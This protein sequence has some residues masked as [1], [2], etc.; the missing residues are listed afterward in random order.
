MAVTVQTPVCPIDSKADRTIITLMKEEYS[1]NFM[2]EPG[3]TTVNFFTG[4]IE[5]A[6]IYYKERLLL[7]LQQNP[8]LAGRLEVDGTDKKKVNLSYPNIV[9][10]NVLDTIFLIDNTLNINRTMSYEQICDV[11]GKHTSGPGGF[12]PKGYMILKSGQP[13]SKFTLAP[14][15]SN[16]GFVFIPSLSHVV[17]DGHTKYKILSMLAQNA[18][19]PFGLEIRRVQS[20]SEAS[21]TVVGAAQQAL[22]YSVP[23]LMNVIGKVLFGCGQCKI[24]SFYVADPVRLEALKAKA[25][26]QA[27]AEGVILPFV[28]T[29]DILTSHFARLTSAR[30]L[31]YAVNLRARIPSLL[32]E[33]YAGNYE[34]AIMLDPVTYATPLKVRQVGGV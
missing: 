11:V 29:A 27:A 14:D 33:D 4:S 8:W 10:A 20:Y 25:K 12:V 3:I 18:E 28:S 22:M 6:K 23:L 19:A 17:G 9:D 15:S 24:S 16:G 2:N 26:A 34:S 30:L 13:V 1:F 32:T 5:D 31:L 21:K 7:V